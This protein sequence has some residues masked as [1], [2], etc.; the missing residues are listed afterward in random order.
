M[1]TKRE[2]EKEEAKMAKPAITD[3]AMQVV[4]VPNLKMSH[5]CLCLVWKQG[6]IDCSQFSYVFVSNHLF[7]PKAAIGP[8]SKMTPANIEPTNDADPEPAW[9]ENF[10]IGSFLMFKERT[11]YFHTCREAHLKLSLYRLQENPK[12]VAKAIYHHIAKERSWNTKG[13]IMEDCWK[14]LTKNYD[15]GPTSSVH[16][17]VLL[18]VGQLD[19]LPCVTPPLLH[20]CLAIFQPLWI[21]TNYWDGSVLSCH[22]VQDSTEEWL[23]GRKSVQSRARKTICDNP[24]QD[25]DVKW[26]SRLRQRTLIL[27]QLVALPCILGHRHISKQMD[28]RGWSALQFIHF[29]SRHWLTLG[30]DVLVYFSVRQ[31]TRARLMPDSISTQ[32][33]L[34]L[35]T[36]EKI[37]ALWAKSKISPTL[38]DR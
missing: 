36:D 29:M 12:G 21:W 22:S 27:K 9:K 24:V 17:L 34:H 35:S 8:V 14:K 1:R 26:K 32:L 5:F 31:K 11:L 15:P 28:N 2:G 37:R 23:S 33:L 18:L 30:N 20:P 3:P 19:L 25:A 4:R 7:T 6:D 38:K 16:V 10:R 13:E